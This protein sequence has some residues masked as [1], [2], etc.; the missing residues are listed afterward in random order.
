M[1]QT[2]RVFAETVTI[3]LK[4]IHFWV[5]M[6]HLL[7]LLSDYHYVIALLDYIDLSHAAYYIYAGIMSAY[8]AR[9][10]TII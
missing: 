3:I 1:V 4:F 6:F 10:Q 8:I 7:S 9:W 2:R 5:C